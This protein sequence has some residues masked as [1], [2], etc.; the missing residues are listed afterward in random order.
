[1]WK[2]IGKR[3]AARA[4]P[5]IDQRID[6][7]EWYAL[8]RHSQAEIRACRVA[9]CLI[10]HGHSID[11]TYDDCP[12]LWLCCYPEVSHDLVYAP[13][14]DTVT[15]TDLERRTKAIMT[16]YCLLT[17]VQAQRSFA[18]ISRK[19]CVEKLGLGDKA[20]DILLFKGICCRILRHS[21]LAHYHQY[22]RS[23]RIHHHSCPRPGTQ[24]A[25]R[26]C[27]VSECG[28]VGGGR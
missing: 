10:G 16:E 1:M 20:T 28:R 8:T 21:S 26:C 15:N 18:D 22:G 27:A 7:V 11:L 5:G 23:C 19:H 9:S 12:R 6:Q 25:W 14:L 3:P 17:F 13:R 2:K 24:Q 4:K